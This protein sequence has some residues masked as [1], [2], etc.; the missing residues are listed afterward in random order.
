MSTP[1]TFAN[2][3]RWQP[4]FHFF[5]APVMAINFIVAVVQFFMTPSVAAGWWMV[6]SAA[7]VVLAF[8]VRV[9]PLKAQDRIIRLEER[10][11]F[12]QLLQPELARRINELSP[13][14]VCALRFAGDEELADLVTQ[15]MAGK[16]ARPREIKQAVK[17]WRAD[18]FRV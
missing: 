4:I 13:A 3:V 11:R 12:Q 10:L 7:L 8:L 17:N 9:N 14:Q 1:Q 6:V 18:T 15:T 16:Y 2:H 5:V